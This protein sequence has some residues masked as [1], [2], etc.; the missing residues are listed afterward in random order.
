[1]Y[2]QSSSLRIHNSRHGPRILNQTNNSD[3][4]GSISYFSLADQTMA[5]AHTIYYDAD[6]PATIPDE[7][8]M[9]VQNTL[10][11][12]YQQFLE[13][14]EK[15]SD[16]QAF[17]LIKEFETFNDVYLDVLTDIRSRR[18]QTEKDAHL[19]TKLEAML[20]EERNSWRLARAL[21]SDHLNTMSRD[22]NQEEQ[23][24][25]DRML[26]MSDAQLIEH[27]YL[28]NH[29]VRR[30]QLVT[31][32]L[33]AN[34]ADDINY[35]AE[36]DRAEFFSSAHGAWENTLHAVRNKNLMAPNISVSNN[37]EICPGM[38]PD[39]PIRTK[40][41][42]AD[43]DK[44]DEFRLFKQLFKYI[45]AGKLDES[46]ETARRVGYH[47][48]AASLDGWLPHSDP[49]FE[50]VEPSLNSDNNMH[51]EVE[52]QPITGNKKRD[53]WRLTCFK[54]AQMHGLAPYEKAIL[55]LYGGNLKSVL[56]VCSRWSDQLWARFRCNIDILIEKTLRDSV[57]PTLDGVPRFSVDYPPEFYENYQDLPLV[58]E[59]IEA[60]KLNAPLREITIHNTVQKFFILNDVTGLLEQMSKWCKTIDFDDGQQDGLTP[61]FLR[62][63]AH[64][65]LLLIKINFVKSDNP[66]ATEILESYIELLTNTKQI[67]CVAFYTATLPRRNQI[68]SFAKLLKTINERDERK[69][70]LKVAKDANLNVDEITQ[71]VVELIRKE[72][73]D[74]DL[75][76]IDRERDLSSRINNR[77]KRKI[78]AIDFLLYTDNLNYVAILHHGCALMRSFAINRKLDAVK[79]TFKRLPINL[80]EL[81]EEQWRIHT[82]QK[83]P[84]E[85]ENDRREYL[86]FK[87]QLDVQ[88]LI[89]DWNQYH[90][91]K[92][93]EPRKPSSLSF[94]DSTRRFADSVNYE[95]K[96]KQY[97][98]NINQWK[99][100]DK[101]N[102]INVG[103]KI[104]DL[105]YFAGGWFKD[106]LTRSSTDSDAAMGTNYAARAY[107][108]Q[109]D[110][111]SMHTD[112][113]ST[114]IV[115]GRSENQVQ[116]GC[117]LA[118]IRKIYIPQF[119]SIVYNVLHLSQQYKE[120]LKIANVLAADELELYKE[121]SVT[122]IREFLENMRQAS[123]ANLKTCS[124]PLGY[125]SMKDHNQ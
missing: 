52:V 58:F 74:A 43:L 109:G 28:N 85:L 92:P 116:R 91:Q 110:N 46:Q 120:C 2:T 15:Y 99:E 70:C 37:Q 1:M 121:F 7:I 14:Q 89:I 80:Y 31:D 32:W 72:G 26:P 67:E 36:H 66:H 123:L 41:P 25:E 97:Q 105:F 51:N 45:R 55:G 11:N 100:L 76:M 104:M 42:L 93:E 64:V 59:Q 87:A 107:L 18:T 88:D 125:R 90:Q 94:S 13:A 96:M 112:M 3:V 23:M 8:D 102:A 122:Q 57:V 53:I 60:Q 47:W 82:D 24:D 22:A 16:A 21:F 79:E 95:Q 12:M 19:C 119:T 54:T 39:A 73:N 29:H 48:F 65:V 61:Q 103:S 33:E 101:N 69:Y 98:V 63:F 50:N 4:N 81:V 115:V 106:R 77:D 10:D 56:P 75:P 124:D 117:Q 83:L 34:Q 113:P 71:T 78:E 5:T 111:S 30:L 68:L 86:C 44:E 27:F 17:E 35:K 20:K 9:P 108:A 38:D 40:K 6:G 114:E 84:L 62:F 118:E 49:N